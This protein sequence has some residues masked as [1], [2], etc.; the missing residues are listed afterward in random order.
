[1]DDQ[2]VLTIERLRDDLVE[3]RSA[4]R[5]RYLAA[6][7]VVAKELKAR[8][9]RLAETW[10]VEI[11]PT[12]EVSLA[13]ER[14]HLADLGVHFQRLLSY[15]ERAT[16]RSKY[17]QELKGIL[18]DYNVGVIIPIKQTVRKLAESGA[19]PIEAALLLA[20]DGVP[21][22]SFVPSAF[23][24]HS[25]AEGDG[26]VVSTV[27]GT[28][29]RMGITV[30][31]GKKPEANRISEK[32]KHLIDAQ[33]FFVGLFT[34]R[35]KISG[36]ADWMPSLWIVDEK[37]YAVGKGKKLVL[38]KEEGVGSIGG[39][40]GSDYEHITFRRDRLHDMVGQLLELF[41]LEAQGFAE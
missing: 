1:M 31:T 40:Q 17:D 22:A 21:E 32:V 12:P 28:L 30:V 7:Q 10:M 13:V 36:K 35:E 15:S 18:A 6:Q 26:E 24:G 27:V 29:E 34:R 39:I 16:L 9:S 3:Y 25:F 23:V 37:A 4:L 33:G 5:K 11:A 41:E 38:V 2:L 20:G 14:N 8:A 19:L